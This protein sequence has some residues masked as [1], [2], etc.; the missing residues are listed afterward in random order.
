MATDSH[1]DDIDPDAVG[2]R[3]FTRS[4]RGFDQ[5]EVRAFL[6]TVAAQ[7]RSERQ[8]QVELTR[9][10]ADAESRAARSR[11]SDAQRL[12]TVLG[13][14]T[15][16]II[17]AAR[18]AAQEMRDRAE[19]ETTQVREEAARVLAEAQQSAEDS[20]EQARGDAVATCDQATTEAMA[21]VEQAKDRAREMVDE[22][23]AHRERVMHDVARRRKALRAQYQTLAGVRDQMLER[24]DAS[25]G[26][27]GGAIDEVRRALHDDVALVHPTDDADVIDHDEE[28]E[29]PDAISLEDERVFHRVRTPAPP[30]AEMIDEED[31]SG[32]ADELEA[33]DLEEPAID[34]ATEDEL[35]A[36]EAPAVADQPVAEETEEEMEAVVVLDEAPPD[37]EWLATGLASTAWEPAT[38]NVERPGSP[39]IG[40]IR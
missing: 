22:A 35:V 30:I 23:R 13:E 15:A 33:A 18:E 10:L 37:A 26:L 1:S 9:K 38:V 31:P 17:E 36:D 5:I 6:N 7:L 16:R 3:E 28:H 2:R 29:D 8:R 4:R 34:D 25:Q 12:T 40:E 21:E 27:L 14:E 39:A 19:T 20:I 32:E 11:A 24:L